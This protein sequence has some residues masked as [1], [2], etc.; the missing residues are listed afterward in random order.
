[1]ESSGLGPHSAISGG[2]GPTRGPESFSA[3]HSFDLDIAEIGL[4]ADSGLSAFLEQLKE[5]AHR[6]IRDEGGEVRRTGSAT[7]SH[8]GFE[9]H[10]R[11]SYIHGEIQVFAVRAGKEK[12][13]LLLFVHEHRIHP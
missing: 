10:Y 8:Y 1:M 12:A 5:N 6:Q 7:G 9:M 13:R 11:V 2:G 3:T 4:T